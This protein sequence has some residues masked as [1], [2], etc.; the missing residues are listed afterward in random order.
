MNL[1]EQLQVKQEAAINIKV[2]NFAEMMKE[3]I[4]GRA[5]QG[6]S[7]SYFVIKNDNED[8]FILRSELF[9]NKLRDLMDGVKVELKEETVRSFITYKEKRIVFSWDVVMGDDKD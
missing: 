1:I 2:K 9:I 5:E 3:A 8:K 4:I 7:S 6:H